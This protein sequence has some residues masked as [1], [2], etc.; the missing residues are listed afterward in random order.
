MLS[1]KTIVKRAPP[2]RAESAPRATS[3]QRDQSVDEKP[4]P[5]AAAA[6]VVY[7]T[8]RNIKI[9]SKR[10]FTFVFFFRIIVFYQFEPLNDVLCSMNIINEILTYYIHHGYMAYSV[11]CVTFL[12]NHKSS[13]V[14][15]W[16]SKVSIKFAFQNLTGSS[17]SFGYFEPTFYRNTVHT[18]YSFDVGRHTVFPF[19]RL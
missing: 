15:S 13:T 14:A 2:S 11:I 16:D 8:V 12:P 5:Y 17:S 18:S 10:P 9:Q 19:C 7:C 6:P 3:P 4:I 1:L